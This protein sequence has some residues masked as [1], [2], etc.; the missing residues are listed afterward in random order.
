MQRFRE[1]LSVRVVEPGRLVVKAG[2]G[3]IATGV[4]GWGEDHRLWGFNPPAAPSP[5]PFPHFTAMAAT[6]ASL[7]P[8]DD[9]GALIGRTPKR[10]HERFA[11]V[12]MS[13]MASSVTAF[14]LAVPVLASNK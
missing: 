5:L 7:S 14:P 6:D 1:G 13:L 8:L 4:L 3:V 10:L 11:D 9:D 12:Q 2:A